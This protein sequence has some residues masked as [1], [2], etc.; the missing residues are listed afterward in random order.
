MYIW[1]LGYAV[2]LSF[3]QLQILERNVVNYRAVLA[4]I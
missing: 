3:H 1:I 2:S 4:I